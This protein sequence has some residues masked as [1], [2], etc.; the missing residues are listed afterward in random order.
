MPGLSVIRRAEAA[1]EHDWARFRQRAQWPVKRFEHDEA[2]PYIATLSGGWL[3]YVVRYAAERSVLAAHSSEFSAPPKSPAGHDAGH[4][5]AR[6]IRHGRRAAPGATAAPIFAARRFRTF[7]MRL[8]KEKN[9]ASPAEYADYQH[10]KRFIFGDAR[11]AFTFIAASMPPPPIPC[12]DI[13]EPM[14]FAL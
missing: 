14:H 1:R 4:S 9:D 2:S 13:F 10:V 8:F 12:R 6:R 7:L 3:C 5:D 11:Q